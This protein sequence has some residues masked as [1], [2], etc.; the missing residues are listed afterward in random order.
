M[1]DQPPLLVD[2]CRCGLEKTTV[3]NRGETYLVCICC[4]GGGLTPDKYCRHQEGA[5]T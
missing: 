1:V 4:G 2:R 5:K 3:Q